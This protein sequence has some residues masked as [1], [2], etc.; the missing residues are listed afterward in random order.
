M[1]SNR[2]VSAYGTRSADISLLCMHIHQA[3]KTQIRSPVG[4][5]QRLLKMLDINWAEIPS[6]NKCYYSSLKIAINS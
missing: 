1:V 6:S 4:W 2:Y 5:W 3:N